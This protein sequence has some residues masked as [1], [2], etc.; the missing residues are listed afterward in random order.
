[1]V[2]TFS[3]SAYAENKMFVMYFEDRG[4]G[5]SGYQV[6]QSATPQGPFKITHPNVVVSRRFGVL[7]ACLPAC[8]PAHVSVCLPA[9]RHSARQPG[10]RGAT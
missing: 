10:G 8:L 6:A 1:M 4:A 7:P 5:L 3:R 2:L 9:C